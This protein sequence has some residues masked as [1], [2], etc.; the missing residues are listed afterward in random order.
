VW[1]A[2]T[3]VGGQDSGYVLAVRSAA[4]VHVLGVQ[5]PEPAVAAASRYLAAEGHPL[6]EDPL[7]AG[8]L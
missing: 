1:V 2:R 3:A 6:T 4:G 7:P 5:A 8:W